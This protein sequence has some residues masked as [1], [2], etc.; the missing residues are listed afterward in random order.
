MLFKISD[1]NIQDVIELYSPAT[2]RVGE[3]EACFTRVLATQQE[4][5]KKGDFGGRK[6]NP[7]SIKH[8]S[9]GGSISSL[10]EPRR[11]KGQRSETAG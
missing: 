2:P 11:L 4:G 8:K 7:Q 3:F 9:T 6:K 10:S 5:D 1:L